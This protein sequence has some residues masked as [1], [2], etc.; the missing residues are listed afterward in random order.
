[1]DYT[2]NINFGATRITI[3][4]DSKKDA[5]EKYNFS[6]SIIIFENKNDFLFMKMNKNYF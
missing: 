4:L 2:S 3:F 6:S 5:I 1:M